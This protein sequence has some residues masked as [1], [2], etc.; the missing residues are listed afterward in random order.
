MKSINQDEGLKGNE[1]IE[2][3][4]LALQKEATPE[5]LAHALT[6]IRHRVLEGGQVI[7]AVEPSLL[8]DQM[9]LQT[10]KTSDGKNWW[11]AFTCF[12]EELK[13]ADSVKSTFLT[14]MGKLFQAALTVPEIQGVILNPYNRTIQLDKHLIKILLPLQDEKGE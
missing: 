3:A 10:V 11:L 1:K 9:N 4:I 6:V 8:Q 12:D 14:D 13:G 5:R 7:V 2:E